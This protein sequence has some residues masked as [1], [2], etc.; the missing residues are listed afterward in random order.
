MSE[1]IDHTYEDVENVFTQYIHNEK[2]LEL[3][4]H[5]YEY[6]KE[7][8][9]GQFRK[10]GQPYIIHLIFSAFLPPSHL[11]FQIMLW[12]KWL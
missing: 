11:S 10:S 5:S 6:A 8:H 1:Y 2:D 9:A 7:K 3:I 12:F 4:R